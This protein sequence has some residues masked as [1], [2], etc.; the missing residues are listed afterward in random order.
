MCNGRSV[1]RLIAVVL[2][3]SS[4]YACGGGSGSLDPAGQVAGLVEAPNG[5]I[6]PADGLLRR[7]AR[8]WIGV[9]DAL[10][11]VQP[12]PGAAVLVAFIDDT[13]N[14]VRE[15]T[16]TTTDSGG[17][18]RA[19]L[20][21]NE[22]PGSDFTVSVGSAATLMRAFVYAEEVPIDSASEA[23]VRLV[24]ASG[25][26][27]GNFSA[28]ELAEIQGLVDEATETLPAGSSIE[29]ANDRAEL[30]AAEDDSVVAAI[31]AAGESK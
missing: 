21:S 16:T 10:T 5:E 25:F 30:V 2:I 22:K 17:R 26:S 27:L 12:V 7:L 31:E 20:A 1:V 9:A 24:L 15:L 28:D 13:G 3:V 18:Y 6:V 8:V 11:G 19:A 29:T 14:V 23:S 4:A